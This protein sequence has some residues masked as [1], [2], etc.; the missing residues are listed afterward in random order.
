M[1]AA[2]AERRTAGSTPL[3]VA[4]AEA[5]LAGTERVWGWGGEG[6]A[7]P[8]LSQPARDLLRRVLDLREPPPAPVPLEWLDMPESA[9]PERAR[10]R[11]LDAV[12]EGALAE[13]RAARARRAAGKSYEDIVRLR[14]GDAR[15]APDAVVRPGSHEEVAATLAACAD[16][17]VA[18]V[19]FGG[20]TSVVG[21]VEALRGG[22]RAAVTLDVGRLD[23]LLGLDA[24][25]L[26]ATFEAGTVGRRAEALLAG[27]GMTLGHF[28]QSFEYATLG[29]YLAT[30]S[31]GQA[32]TGFGR[33]EHL[34][35]GLRCASPAGELRVDPVPASAAGPSLREL[36]VGSEG[37]FGVITEA[38][39]AVRPT[40]AERR[41]EGWSFPSFEAGAEALRELAQ[42]GAAPD[43][44]R[45]SDRGET[46]LALAQAGAGGGATARALRRYL[47]VRGQRQPC[48]AV[49]GWEGE[50]GENAR[51]RRVAGRSLRATGGLALGGGPGRAWARSRFDGPYLRDDLL[52]L[53]VLAETL[54]TATTW[55]GLAPLHRAVSGALE[56]ALAERGTPPLVGCHVSHVYRSG[57]SLYF[58]VLA[59]QERGAELEQWRAAKRAASDAIVA[60]GGTITHHH[61]V[62]TAHL[63]WIEVERG[64]LGVEALRAVKERLDPAGLM[65]PGKL[66]PVR[67]EGG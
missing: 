12:G 6:S 14:S 38:T 9:L 61:A 42:A 25:S 63:P 43:V 3:E 5:L 34:V 15:G 17:G 50:R 28:P 1:P 41:Y 53:G 29:G 11:L 55:S 60:T 37:A 39:L 2:M 27:Q 66:L 21:G 7:R 22:L 10:T 36:L 67:D 19:P 8:K 54:E 47:R 57:A 13:D 52:S 48:L 58:T 18:V 49:V 30:R 20:G 24:R 51:R 33:F 26:T 65:N 32:S 31:A 44:A 40:P 59:R 56:R 46:G 62:G 23:R 4:P 64:E 16:E 45:L 35:L